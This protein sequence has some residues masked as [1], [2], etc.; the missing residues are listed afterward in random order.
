MLRGN[1][2]SAFIPWRRIA[3]PS[4]AVRQFTPNWFTATMGT[5]IL[6]LTVAQ[7][8]FAT[9]SF[10]TIGTIL[11][12]MNI[13]LFVL[14]C[15]LTIARATFYWESFKPLFRHPAQ[16]LFLG[17]VPM[18]LA[19]IVNGFIAFGTPLFGS[20][21]IDIAQ[22]L[23]WVDAALAI[24]VGWIVPYLMFTNQS[25]VIEKMTAVWLLPIVPSEVTA[26]SGGLLAPHVSVASANTIVG[27]S[28]LLWTFS[29]PLAI[30]ILS[31]LFMRLALHSIPPREMA[32]SSW[33]TLGPLGTGS[34]A[35]VLLGNDALRAFAGTQLAP[36][37]PFAQALGLIVG[38]TLWGYGAWWWVMAIIMTVHYTRDRIPFN[39]GWWGFTFPL[40]VFAAS[41]FALGHATGL[42]GYI[43]VATL[44]VFLLIVLWSIVMSRT[45][46]GAWHGYLFQAPCLTESAPLDRYN[47]SPI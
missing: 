1:M 10:H 19:T 8:P 14:F 32:A 18:A 30:G 26:A 17:A 27:A 39:L 35:A 46:H 4:E 6:A 41:T 36:I 25:H 5:G 31:T 16:S 12:L 13:A 33:L 29:V 42:V 20:R 43:V 37:A 23:W 21:A 28:V 11:W 34:L 47:P 15:G 7:L 45:I 44:L 3:H 40:G 9:A 22:G 38:V 24:A 2:Y